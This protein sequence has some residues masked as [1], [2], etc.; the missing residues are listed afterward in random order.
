MFV[1]NSECKQ[2]GQKFLKAIFE[3]ILKKCPVLQ[4]ALVKIGSPLKKNKQTCLY[5]YSEYAESGNK[6]SCLMFCDLI[7]PATASQ[8]ED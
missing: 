7:C 3:D 1:S 8:L 6:N 5:A 2:K 4:D